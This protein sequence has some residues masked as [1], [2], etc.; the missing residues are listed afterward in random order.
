MTREQR[1]YASKEV[2]SLTI[3]RASRFDR[4][5]AKKSEGPLYSWLDEKISMSFSCLT[6]NLLEKQILATKPVKVMALK[7]KIITTAQKL[8]FGEILLKKE[9]K[10]LFKSPRRLKKVYVDSRSKTES[11]YRTVLLGKEL[12]KVW[13]KQFQKILTPLHTIF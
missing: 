9:R 11:I 7:I 13:K 10:Q 3:V 5:K 12:I 4:N 6:S 8:K 1:F 2:D